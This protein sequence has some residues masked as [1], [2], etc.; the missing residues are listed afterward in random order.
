[1]I[2]FGCLYA[3]KKRMGWAFESFDLSLNNESEYKMSL[4]LYERLI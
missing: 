1:M 4:K 3:I 2:L